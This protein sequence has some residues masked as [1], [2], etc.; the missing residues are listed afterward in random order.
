MRELAA[1]GNS[2]GSAGVPV[3]VIV[4]VYRGFEQTRA[5]IESV[6]AN[7]PRT[8]LELIVI[9]DCAPEPQLAEWLD[10]MAATGKFSLLRN[11][12]NCGFVET[13]NRGMLLHGDRDVLLLNS[14]TL[15]ANDWLDRI[16]ACAVTDARIATVTP[17]SNNATICSYPRIC[18]ANPLPAG[19]D[20]AALDALFALA[21][22]GAIAELPTG[23]GFCLYIR[24]AALDDLGL[25]DAAAFGKGYG[26]ENDFCR[27]ANMRGW[28][29]VLAAGVFVQ[30][31]GGVS[32]G[33]EQD[34]LRAQALEVLLKRH[35]DYSRD[36]HRFIAAD[37]LRRFRVAADLSRLADGRLPVILAVSH[38]RGGGTQKHIDELASIVAGKAHL[39]QL[40]TVTGG[41][42]ELLWNQ[43]GEALHLIYD[44]AIDYGL[45]LETLRAALVCRVHFHSWLDLPPPVAALARELGLPYDCTIHDYYLACPQ[46]QFAFAVD[47]HYCGEKGKSQC[48]ECLHRLPAPQGA[49]IDAWRS[50]GAEILAGASRVLAPSLDVAARL[51]RYFPGIRFTLAPHAEALAEFPPPRAPARLAAAAPLRVF[52]VG[53]LGKSK[54]ADLL[55]ACAIDAARRA[56]P[57]S[58]ELIGYGY[59]E[60]GA[61][62]AAKLRVHGRYRDDELPQLLENHAPDLV[63]FPALLPETYSYTLS[64]ALAAGLPVAVPNLGAFPERVAGRPS[65]WV[66]DWDLAASAVNDWLLALRKDFFVGGAAWAPPAGADP[67]ALAVFRYPQDYL[68]VVRAAPRPETVPGLVAALAGRICEGQIA[69][70]SRSRTAYEKKI[71]E[72]CS[73][74][75]DYRQSTS[76]R[77]TAPLRLAGG[78]LRTLWRAFRP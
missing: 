60:L 19:Y 14:D 59:R 31:A 73:I 50:S 10:R 66:Y 5:C 64:S 12:D 1:G 21:N 74:V 69:D 35:P 16:V 17:F 54:G 52:V 28:K 45:L 38:S 47:E 15:V 62:S 72:L 67:Q 27:R 26:E 8:P 75:D 37:P 44:I 41:R 2:A 71:A 46:I 29:N 25:F 63:W 77:I 53:A 49:D 70:L 32:F 40:S 30:H 20:V 23:I 55:E 7:R 4:P 36:V 43:P 6:L 24:R 34:A 33:A 13:V 18:E 51:Q 22:P 58:F 42:V 78:K 76:W 48:G 57:L 68:R 39:L 65:S 61:G 11:T 3:D 56:L 9:D